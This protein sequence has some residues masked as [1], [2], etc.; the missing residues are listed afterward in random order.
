MSKYD[1]ASALVA[2]GKK[3]VKVNL[4]NPGHPILG[5]PVDSI[6]FGIGSWGKVDYLC[7]YCGYTWSY[8]K[9]SGKITASLAKGLA[10]TRKAETSKRDRKAHNLTDKTKRRSNKK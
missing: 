8:I 2:L 10:K 7:H 9:G 4:I 6:N 5:I 3:G 1:E